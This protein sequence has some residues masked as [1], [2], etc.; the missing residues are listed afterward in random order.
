[1][2]DTTLLLFPEDVIYKILSRLPIKSL[3]RFRCVCKSWL[4][5][6]DSPYLRTIHVKEEPTPLLFQPFPFVPHK[7]R[8][9]F[10]RGV[11]K[12]PVLD[13][14]YKTNSYYYNIRFLGSCNGLILLHFEQQEPYDA[15]IYRFV[16]I[17]PLTKGRHCLPPVSVKIRS[18]SDGPCRAVG[19]GFDDSTNTFKTV[20]SFLKKRKVVCTLV[21]SSGM[22][23]WRKIAQNPAYPIIGVG[24]FSDGRLHWLTCDSEELSEYV[25]FR[26]IVWFDVKTEEFG[27]PMDPPEG[28]HPRGP[29]NGFASRLVDLNGE[30]GF[31]YIGPSSIKLWILKHEEWVL[32]CSFDLGPIL[33][34][35][36]FVYKVEVFGCWNKDGDI[37]LTCDGRERLFVYTL[38]S[39]DLRQV[40]LYDPKDGFPYIE[41]YQSSFL[42]V[43]TSAYYYSS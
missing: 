37:L 10:L 26:K 15:G 35:E 7:M 1:M 27:L 19:I 24:V 5:Y 9:S 25:Y 30:V 11:K 18:E 13:L 36:Y 22:S 20:F 21:H 23:L 32:H 14:C 40:E 28:C 42:S 39:G 3:A 41:M 6:I 29:H 16:V 43:N 33:P 2:A 38:K 31:V 4:K 17:D 12:D 34:E 8:I